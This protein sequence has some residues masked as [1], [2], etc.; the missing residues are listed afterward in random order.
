MAKMAKGTPSANDQMAEIVR[1]L[2]CLVAR[3]LARTG[4]TQQAI[5]KFLKTAKADVGPMVKGIKGK[6]V[7]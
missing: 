1:L 4:I 3:D 7:A 5:A 2:Q 6:A